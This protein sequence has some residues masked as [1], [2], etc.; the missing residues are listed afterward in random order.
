MLIL[1]LDAA[2]GAVQLVEERLSL[3]GWVRGA[4]HYWFISSGGL[5]SSEFVFE[6]A[7]CA[8]GMVGRLNER[9]LMRVSAGLNSHGA[10]WLQD[11]CVR[12]EWSGGWGL[13]AGQFLVPVSL[14]AS[15]LPEDYPLQFNGALH[16]GYVKPAGPYDVGLMG[17]YRSP[18][19]QAMVSVVNGLGK[20][21]WSGDNRFRKDLCG[22][23]IGQPFSSGPWFGA[24]IYRALEADGQAWLTWGVEATHNVGQ[25]RLA[26]EYHNH[27]SRSAHHNSGYIQGLYG[28]GRFEPGLRLET[29][30]PV[31]KR[32]EYNITVGSSFQ[33]YDDLP[34]KAAI[35]YSLHGSLEGR[36]SVGEVLVR[37]LAS[38]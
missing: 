3:D 20:D 10:F 5:A 19:L 25:L 22:R 14:D 12:F 13:T 29:I 1:S 38:L 7:D 28:V 17:E 21:A 6:P 16:T 27:I 26:A 33:P 35:H 24:R 23:V 2:R 18:R 36:W 31:G 34:V 15:L 4:A 32:P 30:V 37:L 11:A 8:V 9:V